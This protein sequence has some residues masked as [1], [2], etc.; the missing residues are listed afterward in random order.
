MSSPCHS[1]LLSLA[2]GD[3]L[4][5][6]VEFQS[7]KEVQADPVTD[8]RG[9]GTH[10]QPPGTWSDDSSLAFC[11]AEALAEGYDLHRIARNFV[12]WKHE[13]WWTAHN[14]VFDIGIATSNAIQQL[15]RG[16]PPEEAGGRRESDNGNGSLMRIAPLVFY[17][18]SKP[19]SERFAITRS[20][21]SLT[22][23]HIRSVIAC[24]YLLEFMRKQQEGKALSLV[25]TELQTEIPAF[26][27]TQQIAPAEIAHFNRLFTEEI[28]KLPE[29]SIYSSGY[30][31][32]TL[33]ASVWC[34]LTTNTFADA[35]LRAVNLGDD[36]DTTGAVTGALAGLH[37]GHHTIPPHWLAQ[38]A[39]KNDIENLAEKL[40][41]KFPV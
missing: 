28:D 25:Y 31:I 38:L 41:K 37:Y 10:H 20:V 26:L 5:V 29:S 30:V 36:T 13:A 7:R 35:V 6:P 21:S 3:A 15:A 19:I 16:V 39:R 2:T 8:M 33:E 40:A 1:L 32:H 17:T 18:R 22:H 23:A 11:L 24:F 27:S 14:E 12:R 9:W 4:G 34:L